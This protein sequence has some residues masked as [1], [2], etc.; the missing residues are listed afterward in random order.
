MALIKSCLKGAGDAFQPS[1]GYY[2]N[3]E[4]S[5]TTLYAFPASETGTNFGLI[6]NVSG[7]TS[8]TY[9]DGGGYPVVK[10]VK[11]DGTVVVLEDGNTG[12]NTKTYDITGF[13]LIIILSSSQSS[14]TRTVS[15]A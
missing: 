11:N 6:G 1:A 14:K 13:D 2:V 3:R 7:F 12:V 15:V 9:N 4:T 10:G 8:M 5:D